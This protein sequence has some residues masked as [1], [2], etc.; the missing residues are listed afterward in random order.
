M[1]DDE[2]ELLELYRA[3]PELERG[4]LL[5]QLEGRSRGPLDPDA[6]S[7]ASVRAK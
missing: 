2:M 5:G 6:A 7:P 4:R 1:T 3:L